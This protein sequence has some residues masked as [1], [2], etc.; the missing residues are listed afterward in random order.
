M[1]LKCL[2]IY[3][4]YLA[5]ISATT[6]YIGLAVFEILTAQ[7]NSP[8]NTHLT[9]YGI[10]SYAFCVTKAIINT[11]IAT[12]M[13]FAVTIGACIGAK[14]VTSGNSEMVD[15]GAIG[16]L[17]GTAIVF[18]IG[19][20]VSFDV[21]ICGLVVWFNFK[22]NTPDPYVEVFHAEMIVSFILVAMVCYACL[23]TCCSACCGLWISD[24]SK[25]ND[26]FV[27]NV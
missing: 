6:G 5:A 4:A 16:S 20:F 22:D 19:S 26:K 25:H 17:M 11:I 1:S 21:N 12:F 27:S 3:F 2:G 8:Q 7:N 14:G 24:T 15:G 23:F 10:N 9:G 13:V 18:C